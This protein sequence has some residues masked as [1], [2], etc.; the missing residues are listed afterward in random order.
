MARI[1][2]IKPEFFTSEDI[3]GLSPL[4]RLLYIAIWCESDREGRLAWKP[5]TF[6]MRYFP[7]DDCDIDALAHELI[8]TGLVVEYGAGLAYIPRFANHQHVNPREHQSNLPEPPKNSTRRDASARVT[9]GAG[10]DSDA[11]GGREGKGREGKEEKKPTTSGDEA[12]PPS[13]VVPEQ[14]PVPPPEPADPI[15]GTGL[16]MLVRKGARE[17]SA[18]SFLGQFRKA[19]GSDLIAAELLAKAEQDDVSEPL[20]WLSKAA[21]VRKDQ[22]KANQTRSL[23]TEKSNEPATPRRREFG[24]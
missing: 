18:R 6:K 24:T 3:V 7:A 11:Q 4:A 23:F 1:R 13:D 14:K 21:Q 10:T 15:F 19:V 16:A 17:A 2:T 8:S 12:P 22:A 5:K 20:A 9:D